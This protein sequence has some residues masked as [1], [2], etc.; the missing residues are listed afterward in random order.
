MQQQKTCCLYKKRRKVTKS[1]HECM[2]HHPHL[3]MPDPAE[4]RLV[5]Q[6]HLLHPPED[7]L[8]RLRS[9]TTVV[10]NINE[11]LLHLA[12][13]SLLFKDPRNEFILTKMQKVCRS[14][15]ARDPIFQKVRRYVRR[16][17]FLEFA[18]PVFNP[19]LVRIVLLL[20]RT[21]TI[22]DNEILFL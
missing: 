16:F 15:G 12:K 13:V 18:R 1:R 19:I 8:N 21:P 2:K 11:V 3:Q 7:F 17:A 4:E 10:L 6:L 9:E 20:Y 5:G 14:L 22:G